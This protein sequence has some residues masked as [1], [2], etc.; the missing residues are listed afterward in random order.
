MTDRAAIERAF[1]EAREELEIPA[2]FPPEALREAEAAAARGPVP[3]ERDDLTAV[4]FVTIDPPA[5]RDLDQALHLERTSAGWRLRYAIADVGAFVARGG[6]LEAEAWR[7]GVTYYAPDEKQPLYPDVLSAGAASLLPDE[8]RPAIVFTIDT[9]ARAVPTGVTIRP[10]RLRSRAKLTYHEA[11]DH[12]TTD[13]ETFRGQPWDASLRELRPFGQERQSR[14]AERGGVSLPLVSQR[15]ER[16]AAA[17]LGYELGW[18][19]ANEAEEWNAQLSLLAGHVAAARML[20]AHVGMLRVQPAVDPEAVRVFRRAALALGFAWPTGMSYPAFMRSVDRSHPL[21]TPLFWQAR[22]TMRAADYV[23]FNGEPP[24]RTEHASLAM[25][26]AHV[27]APLRRLGDRYVLDLLVDLEAGRRPSD[28][29][30]ATLRKV[31]PLMDAREAVAGRLERRVVDIAE[32]WTLRGRVGQ[33]LPAVVLGINDGWVDVQ[34][35]GHPIRTSFPLGRRKEPAP[36]SELHLRL[37]DVDVE[38]GKLFLRT[39]RK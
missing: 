11:L 37:T 9:D 21:C 32:A 34:V 7:R 23:V 35:R 33:T 39:G 15:V 27:T 5:S 12:A 17:R 20:Q 31:A 22:R 38:K 19:E 2:E 3:A 8:E 30:V 6:A 1:Q 25:A 36:G 13:G 18:E 24:T 10:A 29:E 4:P 16:E 26:Y 28:A 14:E